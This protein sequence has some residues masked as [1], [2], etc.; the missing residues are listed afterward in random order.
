M[1]MKVSEIIDLLNTEPELSKDGIRSEIT[2]STLKKYVDEAYDTLIHVLKRKFNRNDEIAH[3]DINVECFN[4]ILRMKKITD[5]NE[6]LKYL[7][8]H[9][10]TFK[11]SIEILDN[12][13]IEFN[14]YNSAVLA[15]ALYQEMLMEVINEIIDKI[16]NK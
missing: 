1:K 6:A 8:K 14:V 15:S 11:E 10:P 16:Y 4:Y 12:A 13:G 2:N 5:Y 3:Y 7:Q 9:D